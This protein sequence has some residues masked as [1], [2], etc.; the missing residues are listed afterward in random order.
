[1]KAKKEWWRKIAE[2]KRKFEEN[3]KHSGNSRNVN[4]EKIWKCLEDFEANNLQ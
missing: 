4:K 1:M 2:K 3:E